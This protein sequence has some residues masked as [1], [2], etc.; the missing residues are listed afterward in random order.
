MVPQLPHYRE[1]STFKL[2][3]VIRSLFVLILKYTVDSLLGANIRWT[4]AFG[5]NRRW[6]ATLESACAVHTVHY[7]CACGPAVCALATCVKEAAGLLFQGSSI[8]RWCILSA[9]LQNVKTRRKKYDD[10]EIWSFQFCRSVASTGHA[11]VCLCC[12]AIVPTCYYEC[13]SFFLRSFS[14]WWWANTFHLCAGLL[15]RHVL[16]AF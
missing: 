3:H 15:K 7:R 1:K 4:G 11:S 9:K 12:A 13:S 16:F 14:W 6:T 8:Q 5:L 10:L 2:P